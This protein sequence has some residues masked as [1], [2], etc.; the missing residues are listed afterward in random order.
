MSQAVKGKASVRDL[1]SCALFAALIAVGTF[2][3]IPT[4]LLPLTLQTLFVVLAGLVLGEKLGAVAAG[5]YA[6]AGLMGLPVFAA[7]GGIGYLLNPTF[8][9]ILSFIA[10]AWVAGRAVRLWGR[11]LWRETLAGAVAIALIYIVGA[12][13]YYLVARYYIGR[14]LTVP[15]LFWSFLVLP[16]PGDLLSCFAVALFSH[17][18][19]SLV[20]GCFFWAG[21]V[22]TMDEGFLR[23]PLVRY[24]SRGGITTECPIGAKD[25]RLI[26]GRG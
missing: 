1:V 20:P 4:P 8:G 11:G 26:G 10:G 6:A 19:R 9:Y 14:E 2:V 13:W 5:I 21:G 23:H 18:F 17:R 24:N 25:D 3:K 12:T 7:G 15:A 22:G 16:L